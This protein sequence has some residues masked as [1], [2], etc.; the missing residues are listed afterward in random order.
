MNRMDFNLGVG[1]LHIS[2]RSDYP[3]EI[4]CLFSLCA[5]C[6]ESCFNLLFPYFLR[7]RYLC[8]PNEGER[9][10]GAAP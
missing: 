6:G 2:T 10:A 8:S 9:Y 3:V 1:I 7:F 5:L 4:L